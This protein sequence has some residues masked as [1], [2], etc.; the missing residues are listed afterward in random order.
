LFELLFGLCVLKLTLSFSCALSVSAVRPTNKDWNT[1]APTAM[2]LWRRRRTYTIDPTLH[3]MGLQVCVFFSSFSRHANPQSDC[4]QC[5]FLRSSKWCTHICTFEF[6]WIVTLL[7][8]LI[9]DLLCCLYCCSSHSTSFHFINT[10]L[11][12]H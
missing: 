10:S 8:S 9:G 12:L 11:T 3:S 6:F 2:G 1:T 7:P 5:V 4:V